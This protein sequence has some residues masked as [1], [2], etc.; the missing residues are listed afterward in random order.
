M[1]RTR[2]VQ[3]RNKGCYGSVI[4]I[5]MGFMLSFSIFRCGSGIIKLL[6]EIRPFGILAVWYKLACKNGLDCPE[7]SEGPDQ[8]GLGRGRWINGSR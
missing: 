3:G 7:G 8:T 4:C 5:G 6:R 2:A 1:G